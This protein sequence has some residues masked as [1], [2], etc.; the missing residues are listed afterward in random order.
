MLAGAESASAAQPHRPEGK[1]ITATYKISKVSP[2][3]SD[4]RPALTV[5]CG[6]ELNDYDR[7][8]LCWEGTITFTFKM[9]GRRASAAENAQPISR[10]AQR[11]R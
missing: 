1:T 5:E 2:L 8:Q 6:P 9:D 4:P 11:S 7:T 3:S 10:G